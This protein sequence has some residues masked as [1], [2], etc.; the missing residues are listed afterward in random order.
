M[1]NCKIGVH[2]F[3]PHTNVGH[4]YSTNY[5]AQDHQDRM[6]HQLLNHL[7]LGYHIKNTSCILRE[8]VCLCVKVR[9]FWFVSKRE[10]EREGGGLVSNFKSQVVKK[11]GINTTN[12]IKIIGNKTGRTFKIC[13]N[14][15]FQNIDQN[16]SSLHWSFDCFLC[17]FCTTGVYSK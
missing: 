5:N 11:S 16:F 2:S 17:R 6:L 12:H 7:E 13:I 8:I 1:E 14:L 10:R 9:V 4:F 3:V 15:N